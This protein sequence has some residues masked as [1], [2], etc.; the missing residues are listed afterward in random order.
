MFTGII[1]QVGTVAA[2]DKT[3]DWKFVI[4]AHDLTEGMTLGASIACSGCCLTVIAWDKDSFTVQVSQETLARTTLGTWKRGTK[5]NLER[6]LKVGDELG[7]HFVT[8]HVDG[9]AMLAASEVVG[10]SR[11]WVLEA[12]EELAKY[13]AEKGS[14]TLD[15]VSLTV[16][17]VHGHEFVVNLIPHTQQSTS[18]AGVKV[19]DR[20]NLEVD[21]LARYIARQKD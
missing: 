19:G 16:N 15:G 18:F 4:T 20:L 17:E 6:A 21:I 7:G 11:R 12:P 13:I 8:G 1:T 10:D 9:L 14:V 3:G 2:I 5:I